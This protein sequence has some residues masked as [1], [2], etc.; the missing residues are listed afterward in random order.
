VTAPAA[1]LELRP[2]RCGHL[3]THHEHHRTGAD[4]CKCP[5][6]ECSRFR[7]R[8]WWNWIADKI[9]IFLWR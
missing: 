2:C 4:C 5:E 3:P 9:I 8:R 6:G 7:P 1:A